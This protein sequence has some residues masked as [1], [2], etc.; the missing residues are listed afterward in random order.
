MMKTMV[1][2]PLRSTVTIGS[3]EDT[4]LALPSDKKLRSGQQRVLDQVHSIKRSKSRQGKSGLPTSPNPQSPTTLTEF[5][6]FRFL[7]SNGTFSRGSTTKTASYTK[8]TMGRRHVSSSG[9][10]EQQVNAANQPNGM[11]PSLSDPSLAVASATFMRAKG[12]SAQ[13]QHSLQSRVNRHSTYS[14]TNTTQMSSSQTRL[15]RA[16]PTQFHTDG[17]MGTIKASKIEEKSA[18]NTALGTSELNL[19]EA[20]DFLSHPEDNFQLCGATFIQHTTFKEEHAKQEVAE[21][22]GIPT[23]VTLVRSPNPVVSQAATGA[24]RNLVF[25]DQN[26]K[27]EVQHCGGI[28]KALQ[29]LKETDSTETQKEITGLLWNLSSA[30]ELKGELI[31]TALPALTENVVV[32][33]TSWSD[34][35]ANNNIHPDVFFNATGCLRNLSCAQQGERQAMRRCP[36]LIDSLMNYVQSC[37]A[38]DNPDDKSVE[39]CACILHNLT[40]QLEAESPDCFADYN[41]PTEGQAGR[42]NSTVGCFSPKSGKVQKEFS[43]DVAQGIPLDSAPSGVKWLCHPKAM[44][45]Y[46]SLL[47]SSQKDA[48]LEACCGTMQNLT[49]S[50]SLGSSVMSHFLVQKLGALLHISPLLKAPNRSLQK[51]AMSLL[52]NLS[53]TGSSQSTVA[54]Q[55]LP[56]LTRLLSSGPREMGKSDETIATAC[57]TVRNLM[58]ADTEVTKNVITGDLV[59]SLA[60][61]SENGS[62]PKGS[63]AAALLLYSL[64][65]EKNSQGIV[66]KLGMGK[67]LFV[68]DNTTAVHRSMQVIE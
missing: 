68:N 60:D 42:K 41:L 35:T 27:L 3:P 51:A 54:K 50:K 59:T 40:Y 10:R 20:V 11:K 7:P 2:E 24:L 25:K 17:R 53:R 29:L 61:L 39:N 21:L 16:P 57:N 65:N 9:V 28:G 48:T 67:S 1:P 44:Q 58:L 22:G 38:E 36:E 15:T 47:G 46:L 6:T 32:P 66:R 14:I 62:F 23:L 55:I 37:V 52:G 31:A 45:T 49:A 12:Q 19:K 18:V 4:S 33:F 63:R 56:E 30:D 43:F 34:N 26:N 13:G 8:V 5:G 64:W